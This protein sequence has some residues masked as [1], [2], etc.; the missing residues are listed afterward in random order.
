MTQTS[1]M[2]R[3]LTV[4]VSAIVCALAVLALIEP[5][6]SASAVPIFA[7]KYK[8]SCQ[9][10]H[11]VFPRLTPIGDAFRMN[12][13]RFPSC[14]GAQVKEEPVSLGA[15]AYK[16]LWPASA[17]WPS[18]LPGTAPFALVTRQNVV[19][20]QKDSQQTSNFAGLN[21]WFDV[22]AAGTLGENISVLGKFQLNGPSC[23]NCH[24]YFA[25]T[26]QFVRGLTVKVGRF[27]PELFNFHQQP[28]TEF[29][30]LFGP[31][32]RV[33]ANTWNYGKDLGIEAAA[34]FKGR[35]RVVLGI[36]EGQDDFSQ[37]FQSKNGYVRVAYRLG[38]MRMDGQS[39]P[40]YTAPTKNWRD[41]SVQVGMMGYLGSTRVQTNDAV[42]APVTVDDRMGVIGGDVNAMFDDWTLFGG[43]FAEQ[44][45]HPTGA[46]RHV[47]VERYFAG[48]RYMPIPWFAGSVFFDYFNSEL[49]GD[50][51]YQARVR[52]EALIRANIKLRVEAGMRR[53]V[54]EGLDF[55]EV[56]VMFDVGL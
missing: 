32:R 43:G 9:T 8:T 51:Q 2:W 47:W 7:R 21:P 20:W 22:Y 12:G 28:F 36:M 33:G 53:P 34:V 17:V 30:E 19:L 48:L 13:H 54:G 4:A 45:G 3:R 1:S 52:L 46:D 16:D 49:K 37:P 39:D 24:S 18:E 10:C 29:H 38:G 42:G 26:F 11:T 55:R 31:Q 15:E 41:R 40:G 14:D 35:V 44:H 25:T 23:Q 5:E 6:R 27:Q 50:M 56:R